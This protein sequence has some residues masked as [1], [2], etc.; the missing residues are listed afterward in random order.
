MGNRFAVANPSV[1][2]VFNVVDQAQRTNTIGSLTERD[3]QTALNYSEF[4]QRRS[5]KE[6]LS[7]FLQAT[8]NAG[9]LSELTNILNRSAE[10]NENLYKKLEDPIVSETYIEGKGGIKRASDLYNRMKRNISRT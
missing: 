4:S 9:S 3:F 6:A 8:N 10:I 1:R 7:N 2:K 5:F